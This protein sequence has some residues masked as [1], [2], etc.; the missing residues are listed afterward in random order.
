[1]H[2]HPCASSRVS[3]APRSQCARMRPS[4][5]SRLA[6]LCLLI[7]PGLGFAQGTVTAWGNNFYGQTTVPVDLGDVIAISAGVGHNLALRADGTVAAWGNNWSDQTNVPSGLGGISA[8]AA[9]D[10]HSLALRSDGTVVAWGENSEGQSSVPAGLTGVTAIAAGFAHSLALKS[11]GTVVGW[12]WNFN[13]QTSIPASLTNVIA[14]SAGL[15][16]SMAL[17]SDGTVVAWGSNYAGQSSVPAGLTGVTAISAGSAHSLALQ[18]PLTPEMAINDMLAYI[19]SLTEMHVG[20]SHALQSKLHD[21]LSALVTS[22]QASACQS[23]QSFIDLTNAQRDK[24][25]TIEQADY[26]ITQAS[27]IK[28]LMGCQ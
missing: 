14:I 15:G 23:M 16:H 18:R 11:D 7:L 12:G 3:T 5:A 19:E 9:G 28:S 22:D 2:A 24:K 27:D 4:L 25:I 8:I 1:M 26:I 20:I 6:A 17:K 10:I 13:G 21:A